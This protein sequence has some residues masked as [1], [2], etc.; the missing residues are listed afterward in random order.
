MPR[1]F[2]VVKCYQC[3]QI[4]IQQSKKVSKWTCQ[5]C[6]ERQSLQRVYFESTCAKDCRSALQSISTTLHHSSTITDQAV[7]NAIHKTPDT[8]VMS[9]TTLQDK[10]VELHST[11]RDTTLHVGHC[12]PVFSNLGRKPLPLLEVD[13]SYKMKGSLD[14]NARKTTTQAWINWS[15]FV[16]PESVDD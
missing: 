16:E 9:T 3:N 12:R 10:N 1:T 8:L 5:V 11:T 15:E 6:H 2:L 7:L 4:Q 13:S 14:S